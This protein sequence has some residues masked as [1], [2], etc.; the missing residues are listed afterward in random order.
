MTRQGKN[1]C[2]KYTEVIHIYLYGVDKG[3]RNSSSSQDEGREQRG[4]KKVE[5]R[6]EEKRRI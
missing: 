4:R 1:L 3:S 6:E 5:S 2:T